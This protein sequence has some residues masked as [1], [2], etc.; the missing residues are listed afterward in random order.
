[1]TSVRY[2]HV[3]PGKMVKERMRWLGVL[4]RPVWWQVGTGYTGVL[5]CAGSG[6][7]GMK[8]RVKPSA[9]L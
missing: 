7:V 8:K 3:V 6:P 4:E 2:N 1:M 9:I 5:D